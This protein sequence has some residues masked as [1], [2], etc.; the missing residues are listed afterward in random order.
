[1]KPKD[2]DELLVRTKKM[3]PDTAKQGAE[4]AYKKSSGF[5]APTTS[6]AAKQSPNS[7]VTSSR[8]RDTPEGPRTLKK[9]Q[10]APSGSGNLSTSIKVLRHTAFVEL[11][12]RRGNS[13][14]LS[15]SPEGKLRETELG[16]QDSVPPGD[17]GQGPPLPP[18]DALTNDN[19]KDKL[20]LELQQKIEDLTEKAAI[21][22]RS[23]E[24]EVKELM[25]KVD[26]LVDQIGDE[27][28]KDVKKDKQTIVDLVSNIEFLKRANK[29]LTIGNHEL[30][31]KLEK[32]QGEYDGLS[33]AY[34]SLRTDYD[35]LKDE[36]DKAGELFQTELKKQHDYLHAA[37]L[38]ELEKR[39]EET[40]KAHKEEQARAIKEEQVKGQSLVN[41]LR[42]EV[43]KEKELKNKLLRSMGEMQQA[44]RYKQDSD[45]F[46]TKIES[47]RFEIKNWARNQVVTPSQ[48]TGRWYQGYRGTFSPDYAFFKS[49]VHYYSEY[50]QDKSFRL[51]LQAYLWQFLGDHIFQEDLW[52]GADK[53]L[54]DETNTDFYV[55]ECFKI[56][57]RR[58]QPGKP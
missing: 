15:R 35:E 29:E 30:T 3:K 28:V 42:G 33:P 10:P 25:D 21:E 19:E 54:P 39:S 38:A 7:P 43:S 27:A 23:R 26:G 36:R 49:V 47:L 51:I 53:R 37:F 18:K 40:T 24:Q 13:Q 8:G 22:K 9:S 31:Q 46:K 56:L 5:R 17:G 34:I 4:A 52:A 55:P 2:L 16:P 1:M 57:K 48:P 58:L 41:Q 44:D 14:D 11:K 32:L 20:I 12:G 50:T 6:S 45:Y